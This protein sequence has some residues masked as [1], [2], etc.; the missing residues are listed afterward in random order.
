[1]RRRFVKIGY[2]VYDSP[3]GL[4]HVVVNEIGVIKV[5][6]FEED[7]IQYKKK[8]EAIPKDNELCKE[9]IVQLDEYFKGK[10]KNFD[11]PLSIEGTQFRK[12]VWKALRDI[13]Y[14]ETRNYLQ[15]AESIGNPKAVRAVGQANKYN[16]LPIIIPC[17]RVIGKSG[18]LV[19]FAGNRTPT[20]KLLLEIEG[21][22][23]Q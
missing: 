8:H 5:E 13:P 14:G 20:Q 12:K 23:F 17:H 10:R 6:I 2:D 1:M 3:I 9:V 7:W 19:G 16:Q 15:I 4:I 22:N 18:K 21:F 11:I